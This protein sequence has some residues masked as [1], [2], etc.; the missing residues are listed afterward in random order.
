M[1]KLQQERQRIRQEAF[2]RGLEDAV[3]W[4]PIRSYNQYLDRWPQDPYMADYQ[5]Y[6]DG[7]A[8]EVTSRKQ[9]Q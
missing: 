8:A 5:A 6:R 4:L 9:Q 3:N 2:S 1:N 7:Y